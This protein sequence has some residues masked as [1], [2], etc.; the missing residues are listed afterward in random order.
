MLGAIAVI[1]MAFEIPLPFAPSFYKIDFSEVPALIGCFAMGPAAGAMIELIKIVLHLLISGT[2]TAGVG[3]IANFAI[4]CAFILPAAWIY[5]AKH[6]RKSAMIGMVVGTVFMAFI[7][8]FLNAYVLLPAYAK[9][10]SMPI[11]A[12]V[13]MGTAVN[14]HITNLLTFVVFAVAPFNLL[15]GAMVSAVVLLIY[16]KISPIL[17]MR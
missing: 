11:D 3:D 14:G 10:F 6:S 2:S 5:K 17:K 9:A 4:G 16:K 8:C 15:K 12:L 13:G 1:L 7:G